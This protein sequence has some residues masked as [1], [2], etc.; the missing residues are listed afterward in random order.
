[1]VGD[2][3]G[4]EVVETCLL[5]WSNDSDERDGRHGGGGAESVEEEVFGIHSCWF[6]LLRGLVLSEAR[7][8]GWKRVGS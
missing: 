6:E 8:T 1:L 4:G 7:M 3:G 2:C 5:L